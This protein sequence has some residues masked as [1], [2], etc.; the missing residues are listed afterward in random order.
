MI[1]KTY[2][3]QPAETLDYT[4]DY[5]EWLSRS[6]VITTSV[7]TTVP[8][9]LIIAKISSDRGITLMVSGGTNN[10]IYKITVKAT[11]FTGLV[12]EDEFN[13]RI[14]ET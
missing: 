2:Y 7:V 14:R 12:K 11:T 3:K 10:T 6:D 13:I 5:N 9:D 4:L 1:L 8:N